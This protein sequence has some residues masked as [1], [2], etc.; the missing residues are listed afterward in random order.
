MGQRRPVAAIIPCKDEGER[1]RDCILSAL[2]Q[3]YPNFKV[4]AVNDRSTDD[5]G[6]IMDEIH[7]GINRAKQCITDEAR[8]I[9]GVRCAR[10][11][12]R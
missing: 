5:T 11:G 2:R 9:L 7:G 10:F 1:I 12:E 8:S 4:I 6:R 3:D